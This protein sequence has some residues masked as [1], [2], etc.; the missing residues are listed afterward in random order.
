MAY[1]QTG[2]GKSF[3]MGSEAYLEL[4]LSAQTGLIPRFVND[5]FQRLQSKQQ[6]TD[7]QQNKFKFNDR[8]N[9][10]NNIITNASPQLI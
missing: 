10:N 7:Q 4:K 6:Q 9:N 2:S 3:T 8:D 1:G 5:L